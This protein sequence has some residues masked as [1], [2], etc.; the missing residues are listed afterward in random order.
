[1][2]LTLDQNNSTPAMHFILHST[3]HPVHRQ[4]ATHTHAFW[5]YM[6][7]WVITTSVTK[8]WLPAAFLKL[9]CLILLF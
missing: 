5:M 3:Y 2:L 8:G 4:L 9:L 7:V 1:M 6:Y